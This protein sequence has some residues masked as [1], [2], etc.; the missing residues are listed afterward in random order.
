MENKQAM[1]DEMFTQILGT[2]LNVKKKKKNQLQILMANIKVF[3]SNPLT[4]NIGIETEIGNTLYI[5]I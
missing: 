5:E 4:M 2:Y 1:I 3:K